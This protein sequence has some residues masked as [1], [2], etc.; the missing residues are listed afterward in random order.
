MVDEAPKPIIVAPSQGLIDS[1][2]AAL[3]YIGVLITAYIAIMGLLKTRDIAGVVAYLHEN[4][5]QIGAAVSG[6]VAIAI[7]AY[8]IFKSHKRGAQVATVAADPSVPNRVAQLN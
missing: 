1:V 6:L 7:A 8:G 5:G 2:Q 4:I 3:R